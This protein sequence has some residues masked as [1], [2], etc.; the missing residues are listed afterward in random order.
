MQR[1]M[2][3][4][5]IM[6][7]RTTRILFRFAFPAVMAL[8]TYTFGTSQ[9]NPRQTRGQAPSPIQVLLRHAIP[10]T[11]DLQLIIELTDASVAQTMATPA[12]GRSTP[13]AGLVQGREKLNLDTPQAVAYRAQL[14]RGQRLVTDRLSALSGVQIQGST[15]LVMN[16]I[17]ARVPVEHYLAVRRMPGVKKVYFSRPQRM[18]LNA[19]ASLQNAPVLW[20]H[21]VGGRAN[22][23]QGQ[24]IGLID[25]GIDI[26]SSMFV[27]T[28]TPLPAGFPKYD[29]TADK[30]FTNHKVIVARNYVRLLSNTDRDYTA[31]DDVGHGTFVAG[32][33]AGK[34]V[35]APLAQISGMA[36]GAF[37]GSYKVFGYP[38]YNDFTTTAAILA[39]INDAVN[40]G[41]DVLNL[42]LGS[43]DY[44]PPS[45]DPEVAAISNA[46]A[47]G[48]VVCLAAGNEGPDTHSIDSPGSA[49]DAISVGAIWDSRVFSAQLHVAGTGVPA[50]LQNLA[51][52]N[53]S[54]PAI[55][56]A[57]NA[58][59][60]SDVTTLDGTGLACSALPAG[61]LS[62]RIA[63][64][65]RGTCTFLIKVTD[66]A[67]AGARAVVVYD[68]VPGESTI[69]M[70]GLS[71]THIP[72]VMIFNADGLALKSY[73]ATNPSAT[74][75]IG[76][77]TSNQ[78]ATPTTPVLSSDSSRGPSADFGIKPDLVAVGWNVYSAAIK[79]SSGSI[80]DPTGFY[81]PLASG[82]SFST[83][84]VSGAAAA[85]MQ[86]FPGLTPAGVKSAL[87]NTASQITI[88]GVTPAT[89]VQA[90]N[91]LLNMG[92]AS[93]AGAIFSPTNLN[94]GVQAYSD[95]ISLTQTLGITNDRGAPT[96][97][98]FP[99]NR[100]S[101]APRSPLIRPTQEQL[102]PALARASM[103]PCRRSRRSRADFKDSLRSRAA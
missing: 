94:F 58:L 17:I 103:L 44:L 74:I 16:S 67:N 14:A 85:V 23:G 27:D 59:A 100:S 15:D 92:N 28:T 83:P 51:Y 29:S 60:V 76:T 61:S 21:V 79:S 39:A 22:A 47:A 86:L 50:N 35:T 80:Y 19:A 12:P 71:T 68:N 89:V 24:R 54:G 3:G 7:S 48:L 11:R 56:T 31:R 102:R 78:L 32:C 57:I 37:L 97:S 20:A 70:A 73:L 30:A 5:G 77:S 81:S 65:E 63:F 41:M 66:A 4:G 6:R 99:F 42:S 43:L 55:S 69:Q 52:T 98:R 18:N 2:I 90:G 33:A 62:G 49:P 1:L 26:T 101:T 82:T 36:P 40:D 25:T 91:G 9:A 8:A 96:S 93:T 34:L 13:R 72:A 88:D 10:G 53:G 64:I 95:S 75:S 84:M 45:E 46:I 87:A 38:G